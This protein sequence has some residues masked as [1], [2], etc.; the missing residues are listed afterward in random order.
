MAFCE[1][2][3]KP[4][5]RFTSREKKILAIPSGKF[6]PLSVCYR[7]VSRSIRARLR[8]TNQPVVVEYAEAGLN[9]LVTCHPALQAI[10]CPDKALIERVRCCVP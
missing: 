7:G 6:Q 10:D 1:A 3:C 5:E 9:E 4:S 8:F 2:L